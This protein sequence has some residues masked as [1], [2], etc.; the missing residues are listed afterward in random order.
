MYIAI[1]IT[2]VAITIVTIV[3][4]YRVFSWN[5]GATD[6]FESDKQKEA[7]VFD[8][9]DAIPNDYDVYVGL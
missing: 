8:I 3:V 1:A 6:L 4:K 5:M 2:T 7:L 9:H